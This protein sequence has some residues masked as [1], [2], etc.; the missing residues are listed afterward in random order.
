MICACAF[1]QQ[2]ALL[3]RIQHRHTHIAAVRR[4]R[5][6]ETTNQEEFARTATDFRT[7]PKTKKSNNKNCFTKNC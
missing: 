2:T 1:A 4:G 6:K 5:L 3:T 7:K